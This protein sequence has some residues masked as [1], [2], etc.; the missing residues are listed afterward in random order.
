MLNTTIDE[1]YQ[2]RTRAYDMLNEVS[3][4]LYGDS[5]IEFDFNSSWKI[6]KE[7]IEIELKTQEN[8]ASSEEPIEN[9]EKGGDD[10][11]A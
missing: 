7:E 11:N 4:R 1:M 5:V 2:S 8:E 9:E 3:K 10:E 6:R